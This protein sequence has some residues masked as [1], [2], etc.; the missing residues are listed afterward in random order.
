MTRYFVRRT[1]DEPYTS[2]KITLLAKISITRLPAQLR[3]VPTEGDVL[4]I[5]FLILIRLSPSYCD[6]SIVYGLSGRRFIVNKTTTKQHN[7]LYTNSVLYCLC[8]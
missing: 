7:R 1:F 6:V 4:I 2:D 8:S 3:L 5:F